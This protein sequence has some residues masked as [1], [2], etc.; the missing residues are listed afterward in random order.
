MSEMDTVRL[1]MLEK[2][3]V[4]FNAH[5]AAAVMACMTEDVV[6]DAAAGPDIWGRRLKG[7][8]DVRTTFERTWT[9]ML[10]VS[11]ECTRHAVFGDRALS[12]WIFRASVSGE[13]FIEVEGCDIF[14]FRGDLICEKSAFRKDRSLQTAETK[15]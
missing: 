13:K 3:F 15:R 7:A 8:A 12:E 5:D 10:D 6:F 9:D 1:A 11:W 4:A 14:R 2:L